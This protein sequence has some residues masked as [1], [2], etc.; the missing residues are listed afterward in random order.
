MLNEKV[1]GVHGCV[2]PPESSINIM[3]RVQCQLA[4]DVAPQQSPTSEFSDIRTSLHLGLGQNGNECPAMALHQTSN[5]S[6]LMSLHLGLGQNGNECP[7]PS[8]GI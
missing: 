4:R 7:Q 6:I 3:D 2:R 8:T 5:N 1:S